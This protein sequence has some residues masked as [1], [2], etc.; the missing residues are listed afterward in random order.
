MAPISTKRELPVKLPRFTLETSWFLAC[1]CIATIRASNQSTSQS[2]A[3]NLRSRGLNLSVSRNGYLMLIAFN[4]VLQT[5]TPTRVFTVPDDCSTD[6]NEPPEDEPVSSSSNPLNNI[7]EEIPNTLRDRRSSI[8]QLDGVTDLVSEASDVESLAVNLEEVHEEEG[9]GTHCGVRAIEI[10]EDDEESLDLTD[11]DMNDTPPLAHRNINSPVWETSS[12]CSDNSHMDE[13]EHE[14]DATDYGSYGSERSSIPMS[15]LESEGEDIPGHLSQFDDDSVSSGFQQNMSLG[16]SSPLVSPLP[17]QSWQHTPRW[18]PPINSLIPLPLGCNT[19]AGLDPNRARLSSPHNAVLPHSHYRPDTVNVKQQSTNDSESAVPQ[20]KSLDAD[21][22]QASTATLGSKSGMPEVFDAR[23]RIG[24]RFTRLSEQSLRHFHS[25][26]ASDDS[27]SA[28]APG[29]PKASVLLR[30]SILLDDIR[31]T[32]HIEKNTVTHGTENEAVGVKQSIP[33]PLGPP[34]SQFPIPRPETASF[35]NC[36]RSTDHFLGMGYRP[37]PTSHCVDYIATTPVTIGDAE[38]KSLKEAAS[39]W[40]FQQKNREL[41][42]RERYLP[43]YSSLSNLASREQRVIEPCED[44]SATETQKQT[45]NKRKA[46]MISVVTE[47]DMTWVAS[48]SSPPT[49]PPLVVARPNKVA[50]KIVERVGYAALGGA[51]VGAMVL[52]SLIYSAPTF[53]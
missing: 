10:P 45:E 41:D 27:I 29:S 16:L 26:I 11:V 43:V 50:R 30:P 8:P 4:S 34:I 19:L 9:D 28:P 44:S 6:D 14:G 42:E 53:V 32:C 31:D 3:W 25:E 2:T 15:D 35:T 47:A 20:T 18:L 40:E 17:A 38:N 23:E 7:D 48:D 33:L 36:D 24:T 52:T 21:V 51:T 1:L 39:A 46:E 22:G 37:W 49:A 12:S 13:H 5:T